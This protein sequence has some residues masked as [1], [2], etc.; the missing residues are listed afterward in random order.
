MGSTVKDWM[1]QQA[2]ADTF[3]GGRQAEHCNVNSEQLYSATRMFHV[4]LA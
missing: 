1:V 3:E 4:G 2:L